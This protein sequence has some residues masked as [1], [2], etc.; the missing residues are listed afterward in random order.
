MGCKCNPS[1]NVINETEVNFEKKETLNIENEKLKSNLNEKDILKNKF[2]LELKHKQNYNIL[3]SIDIKDHITYECTLAYEIFMTNKKKFE[4]I[5]EKEFIKNKDELNEIIEENIEEKLF[6]MPP[7]QHMNKTIYEGEFFFD[8]ENN[9]WINGGEGVLITS[10]NELILIK[11]QKKKRKNIEQSAVFYPNGDIFIGEIN[12]EEPYNR[13][14]GIYFEKD[15]N[16]NYDNYIISDKFDEDN[17]KIIKHFENGDLYEGESEFRRNKYIFSGKGKLIDVKNNEIYEGEFKGG[18]FNGK[19]QIYYPLGG[20]HNFQNIEN[21]LGKTIIAKWINGKPYGIG[22]IREKN[23]Q[24]E[25]YKCTTCSFRF[26]KIIKSVQTLVKGKKVL[27]ENIYD[28]LSLNEITNLIGNLETKSFLN[29][30]KKNN[31]K[32]FTKIKIYNTLKNQEKRIYNNDIFNHELFNINKKN[33]KDIYSSLLKEKNYFLPFV[34]YFSDGGEIEKRYRPFNIFNPNKNK[35]YSI[36]YLNHKNK[37]I[38]LKSIFNINLFEDFKVKEEFV[39]DTHLS[40]IENFTEMANLYIFYFEKF[41]K[42]YPLR[43]VDTE[44]I[45]YSDFI[46]DKEKL[47]NFNNILCIFHYI[48]FSIPEKIDELTV[49]TNPC[50]FFA[51]YI[52]TYKNMNTNDKNNNYININDEEIKLNKYD[53]NLLHEKYKDY[54]MKIEKEKDLFEYI[55]FNTMMQKE[56]DIKILCLVKIN[57]KTDLNNSYIIK[58]KKFF[59]YGNAV[60]IKLINQNNTNNKNIEEFS[61]DFGTLNFFGNVIYLGE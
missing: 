32:N 61:L 29:F 41:E 20:V 59:H 28:F 43:R 26:G 57:K 23:S 47:G 10:K 3:N 60:N 11:G 30:L 51:V 24:F 18:L 35:I 36:N 56:F 5:Y 25:D 9:Q 33:S 12:K 27:N 6:K 38:T 50:Y 16:N 34:C 40:Y 7:I 45:D 13:I 58:L 39:Y 8:E 15:E 44:I 17:P 46:L 42:N 21:N 19:G 54:V 14:K 48:M 52:G 1:Q 31:N 2:I 37:D 49:L 4:E 22:L 53:M 55:E